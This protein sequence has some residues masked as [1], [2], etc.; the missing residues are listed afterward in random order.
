MG[1]GDSQLWIGVGLPKAAAMCFVPAVLDSTSE[2]F[3]LEVVP[4]FALAPAHCLHSNLAHSV[5]HHYF[6]AFVVGPN[7]AG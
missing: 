7:F 5:A 1:F 6:L 4:N 3:D 2:N